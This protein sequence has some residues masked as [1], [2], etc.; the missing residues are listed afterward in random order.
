MT[1]NSLKTKI[2]DLMNLANDDFSW[3]L[4]A[5]YNAGLDWPIWYANYLQQPLSELFQRS[6]TVSELTHSLMTVSIERGIISPNADSS[7]F[8][9]LHFI[10][11]FAET[12]IALADSLA[13]YFSPYCPFCIYVHNA[14]KRLNIKVELLNVND[15]RKHYQD[16]I[17][18]RKRA[19]VPVLKITS[20]D[21][22]VRLMPESKDI[23]SYLN[24]SYG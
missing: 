10:E 18:E 21:G 22:A 14:I 6:L 7:V 19:T 13:L 2:V 9:T 15:E 20:N 4:S 3:E 1:K 16:L 11:H 23:V 8:F 24:K 5:N 17:N 12:P